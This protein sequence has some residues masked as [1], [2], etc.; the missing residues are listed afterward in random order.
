VSQPV[1]ARSA[2]PI[3]GTIGYLQLPAADIA[4]SASFYQSVFGWAVDP[5]SG[6]FEAPGMIGQFTTER[7]A[8]NTSGPVLWICAADLG[9]TLDR[10]VSGGGKVIGRPQLDGGERWLAEIDDPAGGRIGVVAPARQAQSQ[11]M[12]VVRDVEAASRWYQQLLGLRSDHGGPDYERL[13]SDGVLV[14]QLNQAEVEHHHGRI[15]EPGA[16]AGNGVLVWFGEVSDFDGVV[17]RAAE[18]QATIVKSPHRN[19]PDGEGNGPGHREIWLKDLDDYTIVVAS[20][21][22]EA[23]EP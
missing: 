19:P 21:D 2:H 1:A 10:V 14:L 15:S 13:L 17:E 16:I 8:S 4:I 6:G 18:L 23:F 20:P 11:P 9:P 22:G 7:A 5:D 3:P 12:L